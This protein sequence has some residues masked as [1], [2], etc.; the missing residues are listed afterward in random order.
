MINI[1]TDRL[2]RSWAGWLFAGML[3]LLI[4]TS[5]SPY[6]TTPATATPS[7]SAET[8]SSPIPSLTPARQGPVYWQL[9]ARDPW[10]LQI[11]PALTGGRIGY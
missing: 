9:A 2:L 10:R 1:K 7:V 11:N 4:V 6:V 8:L 3:V 5:C